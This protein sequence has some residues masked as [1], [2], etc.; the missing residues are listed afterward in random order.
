M[1]RDTALL[2]E[3]LGF[4]GDSM[5]LQCAQGLVQEIDEHDLQAMLDRLALSIERMDD[6]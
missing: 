4:L 1:A 2:H 5:V 6:P 3:A